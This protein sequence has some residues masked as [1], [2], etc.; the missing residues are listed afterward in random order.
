MARL[1]GKENG[2]KEWGDRLGLGILALQTYHLVK[3]ID[4]HRCASGS[5]V[6]DSTSSM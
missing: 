2:S 3:A 6:P 1:G 5:S 4:S